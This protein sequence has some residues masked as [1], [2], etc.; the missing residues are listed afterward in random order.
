MKTRK[1]TRQLKIGG[2]SIGGGAPIVIQ[3][4]NNTKTADVEA[5][6]SQLRALKTAGCQIGRL[7]VP[8]REAAEA[9]KKI[10]PNSPLPLV[11]D[12]H[13]D[14]RLALMS[15]ENGIQ[16]LRINPGNIGS[17]EKV[18]AVIDA[19]KEKNIPIR[20]GINGGSLEKD[21]LQKY[22]NTVEA[23]VES[24]LREAAVFEKYHF[25]AV[26]ISVK[27]SSVPKT[28]AAYELLSAQVDYPLHI[29]VTEAG[30]LLKGSIKSAL[31]I[32]ILLYEGIGDTIRVSL[33]GDPVREITVAKEILKDLGLREEGIEFISC[34][35]CGR[36]KVDLETMVA[37]VE[38]GLRDFTPKRPLT[39]AVM[40]C[41]VNG[42]GEAKEA[43]YGIACGKGQ[44]LLFKEGEVI[45]K[46]REDTIVDILVREI[47]R[48]EQ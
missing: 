23:I 15:I 3:S 31:G 40:G 28:V 7:A 2:V 32:G 8:D 33:T 10:I 19:A 13:F 47:R 17:E 16:A 37:A 48:N 35:T 21:L 36:T 42:P 43:D 18:K 20:I 38:D 24:A 30:T 11:A 27:S 26:K 41:E 14:H 4:M 9:L 46:Y 12:I 29:G 34:P 6:L 44:G 22:G 25:E 45:G 1:K 5:T 39:V